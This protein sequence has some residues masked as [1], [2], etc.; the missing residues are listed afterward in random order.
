VWSTR[1]VV[2]IVTCACA[3]GRLGFAPDPRA[4]ATDASLAPGDIA[5][6]SVCGNT[7]L[8][9]E[10]FTASTPGPQWTVTQSTGITASQGGGTLRFTFG[11]TASPP[12]AAGYT[13]A[14]PI[15]F[16][17]TCTVIEMTRIPDPTTTA[18]VVIQIGI[19][20]PDLRFEELSGSLRSIYQMTSN[21]INHID[22]RAHDPVAH[23]FL[24]LRNS[25]ASSWY[26]EVSTD[27]VTFTTIASKTNSTVPVTNVLGLKASAVN[28][29]T[30]A[31]A[32]EF[33]QVT[34]SR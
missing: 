31:G 10:A 3:C 20:N 32:C 11:S 18:L 2:V 26:W 8:L 12:E 30:N 27:G 22:T 25:G 7:I 21:S 23:R 34:I 16:T 13:L 24:R 9:A 28:T 4:D 6:P 17:D 33:V 1:L 5:P 29:V 14:S 15:D 19:G